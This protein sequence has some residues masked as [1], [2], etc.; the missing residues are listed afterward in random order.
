MRFNLKFISKVCYYKYRQTQLLLP[1]IIQLP[2]SCLNIVGDLLL[3][4]IGKF[5][6][7]DIVQIIL[8]VNHC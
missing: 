5:I 3:L 1:T 4:A 2:N 7:L 6:F 8:Q